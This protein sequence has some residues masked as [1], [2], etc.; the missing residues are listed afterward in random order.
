MRRQNKGFTLIEILM[1]VVI[2]GILAAIAIPRFV[3]FRSEAQRAAEDGIIG[4]VQTGISLY[5]TAQRA[6]H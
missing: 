1:V 6:G 5:D 2:I 4:A 3:S